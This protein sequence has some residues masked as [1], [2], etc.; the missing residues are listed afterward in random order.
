[1]NLDEIKVGYINLSE[2]EA[3]IRDRSDLSRYFG[4]AGVAFKLLNEYKDVMREDAL[5][6]EQP[7]IFSKGF[8]TSIYPCATK[9]T[10]AFKSPLTG[11]LG[12]S[13][14]GG[15]LAYAMASAGLDAIV[16]EGASETPSIVRIDDTGIEIKEAEELLGLSCFEVEKRLEGKS[17]MY[18]GEAGEIQIPF[19]CVTVDRYRH[20]G[21]LGL[22]AL[23]GSKGL[24]AITISGKNQV[25][26]KSGYYREILKRIKEDLDIKKYSQGYGTS[27]NIAMMNEVS[28]LPAEN[29]Q[30]N[31]FNVEGITEDAFAKFLVEK[32]TCTGCPIRCINVAKRDADSPRIAYDYELIY[33][34]GPLL[35]IG[36]AKEV[37]RLLEKVEEYGLDVIATG[38]LLAWATEAYERG[39]VELPVPLKF[40]ATE[41]YLKTIDRIVEGEGIYKNLRR[42]TEDAAE[43][44]GGK[45]FALT[46]G[47]NAMA[48]YHTGYALILGQAAGQRHSHMDNNAWFLDF[49]KYPSEEVVDELISDE[50][51]R[52]LMN[53]MGLCLFTISV[54]DLEL[55]SE[56]LNAMGIDKSEKELFEIGGEIFEIKQEIKQA[57]G[58]EYEKLR[59]PE[60]LFETESMNGF[61]NRET[62]DKM[63]KRYVERM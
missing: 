43:I 63:L 54:Y 17:K 56:G 28:G 6:A 38:N 37:L 46:L 29:L 1:M 48:G 55:I 51:K 12:E 34:L 44:Y 57:C 21:R 60:R 11:E 61:L 10:A 39:L 19:A 27:E 22:G 53:S 52:C 9:V 18:I 20:F 33:S 25:R 50:K 30:A 7:I 42:G 23:F 31:R 24:K 35:G 49:E 16:I 32:K 47:K 59:F 36:E 41:N 14:A 13:H 40:G 26:V 45:D 62:V 8:F 4:G 58:F 3:E 2:E 15:K 5:R